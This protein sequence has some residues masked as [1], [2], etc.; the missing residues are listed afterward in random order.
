MKTQAIGHI[1]C[2]VCGHPD[3][4]VKPDKNGHAFIFCPDCAAQTFT[5]NEYRDRHLRR[6]MRPVTDTVTG[7]DEPPAP[8]AAAP[9]TAKA[10]PPIP[11][12]AP[13][14]PPK[15]PAAPAPTAEPP[16]PQPK[17]LGGWLQPILSVGG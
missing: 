11:V 3:A 15:T 14:K 16:A 8:P 10:P 17:K 6:R 12:T 2:A 9:V 5:R 7:Q 1:E 13:P 4:E